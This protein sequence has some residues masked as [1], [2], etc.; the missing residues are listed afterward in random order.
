MQ[1]IAASAPVHKGGCPMPPTYGRFVRILFVIPQSRRVIGAPVAWSASRVGSTP[2]PANT[3]VCGPVRPR[4]R[5]S[6]GNSVQKSSVSLA[7]RA[8]EHLP[9]AVG[10]DA[11]GD[12]DGMG[13]HPMVEGPCS[14]SRPGTRR[15][16]DVVHAPGAPER[17][18]RV[19][20]RC[21]PDSVRAAQLRLRRSSL[22]RASLLNTTKLRSLGARRA[23]FPQAPVRNFVSDAATQSSGSQR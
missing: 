22:G 8:A 13:G 6:R 7:G 15:E 4:S 10:S 21:P 5:R 20:L 12:D 11:G 18:H 9:S 1:K 3:A 19:E 14:T 16:G 17:D 2:R 23:P